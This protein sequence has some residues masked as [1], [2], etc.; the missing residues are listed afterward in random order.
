MLFQIAGGTIKYSREAAPT[1]TACNAVSRSARNCDALMPLLPLLATL[2]VAA[3]AARNA[4]SVAIA[5][6][7]RNSL[8]NWL[9][10]AGEKLILQAQC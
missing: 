7:R 3:S 2:V 10:A 6:A 9:I 5:Q 1:L 4:L 8:P